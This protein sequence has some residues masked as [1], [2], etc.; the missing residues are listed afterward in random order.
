MPNIGKV[1]KAMKIF[2]EWIMW[3]KWSRTHF[4]ISIKAGVVLFNY[5]EQKVG[6][7][8]TT[9][10]I[11]ISKSSCNHLIYSEFLI[12]ENNFHYRIKKKDK[13]VRLKRDGL[14][15]QNYQTN[16]T[17][18]REP[19]WYL[20]IIKNYSSIS[21]KLQKTLEYFFFEYLPW[22]IKCCQY[23]R[24]ITCRIWHKLL[25]CIAVYINI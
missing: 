11:N 17:K 5:K 18:I 4:S 24:S 19:S 6:V 9:S 20:K 25:D 1:Y 16:F 10:K 15:P 13:T 7:H 14:Y 3:F 23:S 12:A 2:Q 8:Q 22:R 21:I